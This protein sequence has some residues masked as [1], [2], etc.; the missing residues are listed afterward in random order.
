MADF[1]CDKIVP[2]HFGSQLQDTG[3]VVINDCFDATWCKAVRDEILALHEQHLL[4]PSGNVI[5]AVVRDNDNQASAS[6][7]ANNKGDGNAPATTTTTTTTTT[8]N[9][10]TPTKSDDVVGVKVFKPHVFEL[11][12]FVNGQMSRE[13]K[14]EALAMSDTL[15][16]L[17]EADNHTMLESLNRSCPFL[18]LSKLDQIKIQVNEG[19]NGC[20]PMHFDTTPDVSKRHLTCVLYLNP[21]WTPSDGGHIR[22]FPMPGTSMDVEPRFNTL[23]LFC[24][25]RML[26]WPMPSQKRRVVLSLWFASEAG[27]GFPIVNS[28]RLRLHAPV[29]PEPMLR[30]IAKILTHPTLLRAAAKV[31][32]ADEWGKSVE[33]AFGSDTQN[34]AVNNSLVLH[35]REVNKVLALFGDYKVEVL[36]SMCLLAPGHKVKQ[37]Y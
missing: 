11:D 5:K 23:A 26:H 4:L 6:S 37:D 3:Y 24:S 13:C 32:Y 29:E 18:Q 10:I 19:E 7:V 20:F 15:R 31:V 36:K 34:E 16:S 27:V 33:L 17:I 22:L 1:H 30:E 8:T 9:V 12:L 35:W 14:P 28:D 21:D 2:E 25:H